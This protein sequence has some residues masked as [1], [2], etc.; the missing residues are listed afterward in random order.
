MRYEINQKLFAVNFSYPGNFNHGL[1]SQPLLNNDII[2]SE[3]NFIELQVTEHHKVPNSWGDINDKD[4]DGY[5][6]KDADGNPFVNQYPTASY[7]QLSDTGDRRFRKHIETI[8]QL[9]KGSPYEYHLLSD[10]LSDIY[11]GIDDL[12]KH[13]TTMA[14]ELLGKLETLRDRIEADFVLNYP[15][16]VVVAN[17]KSLIEGSSI[18]H[19]EISF[20]SKP[21]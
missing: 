9:E 14:M 16:M 15:S 17:K 2:P 19:W 20:Y 7:G 10:V 8:E 4:C 6:L 11:K 12:S 18:M 5:L 21:V 13:G 3:I 1:Y